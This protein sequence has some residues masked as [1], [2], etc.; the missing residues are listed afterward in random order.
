MTSG[1]AFFAYNTEQIDYVQ[2]AIIA[3]RYAKRHMPDQPVCLITDS[4]TWEWFNRGKYAKYADMAFDDVVI[5]EADN[6][7]NKRTHWDSPYTNFS[8]DFK[9][10]N[11][12]RIIKY[13]PYDRTLLLDV[14][15]IVMNNSLEW[16]FESDNA[17]AMFHTAETIKRDPVVSSQ[18]Y[19][20]NQGVPMLWST[21]LYFNREHKL[22]NLFFDLWS[23]VADEYDFYKFL[24][25]FPGSMYRTDYC[26]SIAT[27]MLNGMGHGGLIADFGMPMI[28]M[29]QHDD[30]TKINSADEWVYTVNNRQETWEDTLALIKRENVHVMNKRSLDR[31]FDNIMEALDA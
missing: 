1:I 29:S 10:G 11:K 16:V 31:Q 14:D 3:G 20:S 15:Y 18:Q 25:S 5:A 27:H 28:N 19:L 7:V 8:S 4:G 17:L 13:S 9:N 6:T 30:V 21:A 22:T 2:L 24:Y 12:H 26:V 23:H